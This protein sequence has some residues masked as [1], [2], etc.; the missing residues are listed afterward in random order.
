MSIYRVEDIQH[1]N[2]NRKA[3]TR[4]K[5]Y[6]LTE[7]DIGAGVWAYVRTGNVDGTVERET[8]ILR[9]LGLEGAQ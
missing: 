2:F 4:F 1:V 9:R 3:V 7:G 8:T 5:L 6:E